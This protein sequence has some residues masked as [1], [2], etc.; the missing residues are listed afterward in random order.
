MD[1]T[2]TKAL[3]WPKI[4]VLLPFAKID[5]TKIPTVKNLSKINRGFG[6]GKFC[7]RLTE[8]TKNL[9]ENKV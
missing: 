5:L 3:H 4:F 6:F 2:L 7:K 8:T 1:G 9:T